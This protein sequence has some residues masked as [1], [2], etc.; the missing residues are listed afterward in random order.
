[1][2]TTTEYTNA[3]SWKTKERIDII[4]SI[5]NLLN[6]KT[7]SES[8]FILNMTK[9]TIEETSHLSIQ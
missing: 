3:E 8:N 5:M 4:N 7:I 1:M 6:N 2:N 9:E